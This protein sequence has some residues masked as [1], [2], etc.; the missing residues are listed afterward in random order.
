[1]SEKAVEKLL[2]ENKAL[3]EEIKELR[4]ELERLHMEHI[5]LSDQM[6]DELDEVEYYKS[7]TQS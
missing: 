3:Q 7:L 2:E 4:R 1:M 6:M 5:R